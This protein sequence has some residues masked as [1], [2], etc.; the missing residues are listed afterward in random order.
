LDKGVDILIATPDRLDKHHKDNN[1]YLSNLSYLV[2]DEADTFLDS[3]FSDVIKSFSE[4]VIR[5]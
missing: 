1:V 2:I 3:G 4:I 5:K